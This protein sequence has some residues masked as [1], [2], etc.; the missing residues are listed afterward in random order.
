[1]KTSYPMFTRE[2]AALIGR[3]TVCARVVT[4]MFHNAGTP[5]EIVERDLR[6]QVADFLVRE[7][8]THDRD[9]TRGIEVHE[10]RLLV[11]KEEELF[12]MIREEAQRYAMVERSFA[13]GVQR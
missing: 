6:M 12:R 13:E 11:L 4:P 2:S 9:V 7:R 1:M 5:L 8:A 10:L 3:N